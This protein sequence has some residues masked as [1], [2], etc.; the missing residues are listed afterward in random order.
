MIKFVNCVCAEPTVEEL[1]YK[2]L[3]QYRYFTLLVYG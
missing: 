3:I 2:G 1:K